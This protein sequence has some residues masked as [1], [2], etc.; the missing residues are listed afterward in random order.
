MS[1]AKRILVAG[2]AGLIGQHLCRRLLA[3]GHFVICLDNFLTSREENIAEFRDH[4]RFELLRRDVIEPIRLDVDETYNLACPASPLHYQTHPIQTLRA[5]V[6]GARNL[7]ENA[8][9]T[10]TPILQA[11]TSEVYGDPDVSPQSETYLGRV[12]PI[13]PRACYDEGKRC[14]ETLFFDFHRLYGLPIR[15]ARIFNTYGPG[16]QPCDGRVV[17]NFILQALSGK[18]ITVYGEGTQTRSFCYVS[19]MVEGLIRL[20]ENRRQFTG[21]VNL[22]N[23]EE[24]SIR[25]LAEQILALTGSPSKIVYG[26]LPADDPRQRRPDISLAKRILEWTPTTPLKEGLANTIEY[27]RRLMKSCRSSMPDESAC[28]PVGKES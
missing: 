24:I 3:E 28:H 19:D 11:S 4:P 21:P 10:G 25:R 13:G 26:S 14:A 23:P 7:L 22:G 5:S 16:Q 27:F 12:N 9:R 17:S 1:A 20:M 6:D 15:V 8:R 2:G 18:D